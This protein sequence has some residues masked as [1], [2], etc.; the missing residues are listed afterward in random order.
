MCDVVGKIFPNWSV[1]KD[2][3]GCIFKSGTLGLI[4]YSKKVAYMAKVNC[5]TVSRN[6]RR[7]VPLL[8][9]EDLPARLGRPVRGNSEGSEKSFPGVV[10]VSM[11]G[12]FIMMWEL[13]SE[14]EDCR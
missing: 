5:R 14:S 11:N 10:A 8:L 1:Q 13:S 9:Q 3:S 7:M 4:Q 6:A 2:V 12:D